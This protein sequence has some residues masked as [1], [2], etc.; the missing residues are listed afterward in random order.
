MPSPLS[1]YW[2]HE[3]LIL[4]SCWLNLKASVTVVEP[5]KSS[6]GIDLIAKLVD[7]ISFAVYDQKDC[8]FAARGHQELY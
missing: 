3:E 7:C 8:M 2:V 5:K 6:N 1:W 4:F